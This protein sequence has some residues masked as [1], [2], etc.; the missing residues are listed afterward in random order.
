MLSSGFIR[1]NECSS[2]SIASKSSSCIRTNM[3][4]RE[5]QFEGSRIIAKIKSLSRI[6]RIGVWF[7]ICYFLLKPGQ[8]WG[9]ISDF[10]PIYANNVV[11]VCRLHYI[12]TL[13]QELNGTKAYEETPIDEKSVD[14]SHSNDIPNKFAVHV[15]ER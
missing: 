11:V 4:H 2:S 15:K 9:F 7:T 1:S 6:R 8:C 13:K 12:D 14:Y 10:P 3:D 5:A